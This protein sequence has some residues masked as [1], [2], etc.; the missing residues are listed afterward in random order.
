MKLTKTLV[1]VLVASF[2]LLMLSCER[3]VTDIPEEH[4]TITGE[5]DDG[6]AAYAE[7][8]FDIALEHFTTAAL[9]NAA[10]LGAY[11]GLAWSYLHLGAYSTALSQFSFVRNLAIEQNDDAMLADS[12]AGVAYI[13]ENLRYAGE[14][15]G[16]ETGIMNGYADAAIEAANSALSIAADYS[17]VH[18]PGLDASTLK[19]VVANAYFYLHWYGNAISSLI[20]AGTIAMTDLSTPSISP[21]T[22]DLQL[23]PMLDEE[24]GAMTLEPVTIDWASADNYVDGTAVTGMVSYAGLIDANDGASTAAINIM[25]GST[26]HFDETADYPSFTE[27]VETTQISY[28]LNGGAAIPI[29]LLK[30][31]KGGI[32]NIESIKIHAENYL[33]TH[34]ADGTTS[35][36]T[37]IVQ[38]D[39]EGA[40]EIFRFGDG[41]P[42]AIIPTFGSDFMYNYIYLPNLNSAGVRFDITYS[43]AYYTA[44]FTVTDDFNALLAK[45][46]SYLN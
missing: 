18:D 42:A 43:Y 16:E 26:I 27:T 32:F 5:I 35:T 24:T 13:Y 22:V 40:T 28:P 15:N 10:E 3:P 36:D 23:Y 9:R 14:L 46:S 44:T 17:T 12:Y 25:N 39:Y 45:V 6:W 41:F 2:T 21:Y 30:L 1:L 33:D 19:N 38:L 29:T 34:N 7:G 8:D 4:T 11:N 37:V 20:D 31:S